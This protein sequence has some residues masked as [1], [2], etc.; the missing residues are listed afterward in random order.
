VW[1]RNRSKT[2]TSLGSKKFVMWLT[3]RM[4]LRFSEGIEDMGVVLINIR[5][6]NNIRFAFS[7]ESGHRDGQ[8][9]VVCKPEFGYELSKT[10]M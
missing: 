1:E 7:R 6:G 2:F 3:I 8:G 9:G 4:P 5:N 10:L